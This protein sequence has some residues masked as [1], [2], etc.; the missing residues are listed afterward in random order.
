MSTEQSRASP[1]KDVNMDTAPNG[2][3]IHGIHGL[4]FISSVKNHITRHKSSMYQPS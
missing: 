2:E 1:F 3:Q 4:L